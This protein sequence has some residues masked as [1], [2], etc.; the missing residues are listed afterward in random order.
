M[1]SRPN[2]V[3]NHGNAGAGIRTGRQLVGQ[4][5]EIGARL[6]EPLANGL[7]V[8]PTCAPR[9]PPRTHATRARA[10]PPSESARGWALRLDRGPISRCNCSRACSAS[11]S[12]NS[13][14]SVGQ[15]IRRTRERDHAGTQQVD[16]GRRSAAA[17]RRRRSPAPARS[18]RARPAMPSHFEDVGEIGAENEAQAAR[19]TLV[20]P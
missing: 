9:P 3:E 20:A 6:A 16:R 14:A 1:P 12:V 5:R 10:R 17:R 18:P 11:T 8:V 2:G 7:P 4:Q 13:A 15:A 19:G